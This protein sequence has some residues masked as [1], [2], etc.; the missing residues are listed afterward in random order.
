MVRYY[1]GGALGMYQDRRLGQLTGCLCN[2]LCVQFLHYLAHLHD[3]LSADTEEET[4]KT[5]QMLCNGVQ[6]VD[7]SLSS[8]LSLPSLLPPPLPSL[9][10]SLHL[11][12]L[13][14]QIAWLQP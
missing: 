1:T 4:C 13:A 6:S 2:V 14:I 11:S 9:V 7:F 10:P 5:D 12:L 8:S 3:N